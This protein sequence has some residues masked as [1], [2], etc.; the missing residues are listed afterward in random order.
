MSGTKRK[1]K[2]KATATVPVAAATTTITTTATESTDA[3]PRVCVLC[4][5]IEPTTGAYSPPE[6]FWREHSICG[7]LFCSDCIKE[8]AKTCEKLQEEAS[9]LMWMAPWPWSPPANLGRPMSVW[10]QAIPFER[11]IIEESHGDANDGEKEDPLVNNI[12]FAPELPKDRL[13]SSLRAF[14]DEDCL[15]EES[16]E[17]GK[18]ARVA[19]LDVMPAL[20]QLSFGIATQKRGTYARLSALCQ[21]DDIDPEVGTHDEDEEEPPI[22]EALVCFT[23]DFVLLP[24]GVKRVDRET[25][26]IDYRLA[27]AIDNAL[28]NGEAEE[29]EEPSNKKQKGSEGQEAKAPE[30]TSLPD[31]SPSLKEI[32]L[33]ATGFP[34]VRYLLENPED[35][36]EAYEE[37]VNDVYEIHDATL[38]RD[39]GH[40]KKG[41]TLPWIMFNL[42]E[43]TIEFVV[44]GQEAYKGQLRLALWDARVDKILPNDS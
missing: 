18:E 36:A 43:N 19:A 23:C 1:S 29:E 24:V 5:R 27:S 42:E 7:E 32:T 38:R 9:K 14:L 17:D 37:A 2:A 4:S 31:L 3:S 30:P 21:A 26:G 15:R 12:P 8:H 40:L 41:S 25:P 22:I 44:N 34:M 39:W 16:R 10:E 11:C 33:G 6:C 28:E 13:P 20:G 35:A